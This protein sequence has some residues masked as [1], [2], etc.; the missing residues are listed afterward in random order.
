MMIPPLL[1]KSIWMKIL[2]VQTFAPNIFLR[3]ASNVLIWL[4]CMHG[5]HQNTVSPSD[6]SKISNGKS[7]A[8]NSGC[9]C[10]IVVTIVS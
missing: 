3:G 7:A 1:K 5:A 4:I 8:G 9:Y 10:A 6:Q 2:G